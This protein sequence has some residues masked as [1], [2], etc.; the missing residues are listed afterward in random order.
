MR[1]EAVQPANQLYGSCNSSTAKCCIFTA[2]LHSSGNDQSSFGGQVPP[3]VSR[4]PPP[5]PNVSSK[6]TALALL[7][8]CG[9]IYTGL[10]VVYEFSSQKL[11]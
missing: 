8:K 5:T 11:H 3:R 6:T 2:S 10:H 1:G 7:C 9:I 4:Y